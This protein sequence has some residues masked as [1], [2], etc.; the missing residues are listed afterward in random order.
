MIFFFSQFVKNC[1]R[2][3]PRHAA[4][5]YLDSHSCCG[6]STAGIQGSF[7]HFSFN[8]KNSSLYAAV[9]SSS[10]LFR[11]AFAVPH[12]AGSAHRLT[13]TLENLAAWTDLAVRQAAESKP[14]ADLE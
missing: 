1:D 11:R 12:W 7:R 4:A 10:S 8:F 5:Q 9:R 13:V 6:D 14:P 3:A 2:L